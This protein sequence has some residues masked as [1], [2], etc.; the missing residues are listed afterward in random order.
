MESLGRLTW[1]FAAG[2]VTFTHQGQ[3][4]CWTGVPLQ[5]MVEPCASTTAAPL[6]DKLLAG[7]GDVFT[8]PSGLPPQRSHDHAIILKPDAQ[9]VAV[10]P[11][12]Y[13]AAHKDELE[14]QCTA[15]IE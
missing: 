4:T 13:P 11:Y 5:E 2:T 10:R 9:P 12:R 1:D 6:L 15:M 3:P 14:R 7:S 8:A